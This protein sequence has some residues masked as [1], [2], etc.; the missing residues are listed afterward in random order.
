V[1][2]VA[3]AAAEA[4]LRR[5]GEHGLRVVAA[6]GGGSCDLCRRNTRRRDLCHA[7]PPVNTFVRGLDWLVDNVGNIYFALLA[8]VAIAGLAL[9]VGALVAA[10]V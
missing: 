5:D 1:A 3:D 2:A 7:P 6:G 10:A 8:L 4:L 9:G